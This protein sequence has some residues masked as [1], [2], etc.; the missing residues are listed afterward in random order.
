MALAMKD[1]AEFGLLGGRFAWVQARGVKA[2]EAPFT[3]AVP[4]V[5]SPAGEFLGGAL[6]DS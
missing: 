4:V 1:F 2:V 6:A 3:L 5:M